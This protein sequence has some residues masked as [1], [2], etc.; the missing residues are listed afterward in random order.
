[1][2]LSGLKLPVIRKKYLFAAAGAVLLAAVLLHFW[3]AG[4]VSVER[5]R[6]TREDVKDTCTEDGRITFGDSL[7]VTALVSGSVKEVRAAENAAVKAGDILFLIDSSDYENALELGRADLA[8]SEAE[9]SRSS[10][11]QMMTSSPAEYLESAKAAET[12]AKARYDAAKKVYEGDKVLA[13]E[14]LVSEL[15]LAT[16]KAEYEAAEAARKEAE[17]RVAEST[18]KLS[19]LNAAGISGESVNE[20]FYESEK[21]ALEAA[22]DAKKT[23]VKQLEEDVSRCTV[24]AGRDGIVTALPVKEKTFIQAGEV[25]AVLGSRGKMRA[26]ADILTSAAPYIKKG[27]PVEAA[28]NLRGEKELYK[29][30]VAEVYDYASEGVSA[31]GLSEYRVHVTADLEENEALAYR[32][33]YGADL[34]FILYDEKDCLTVPAAA[35]FSTDGKDYIFRIEGGKAVQTE[36]QLLYQS[37]LTAVVG[38]GVSEGDEIVARR[39]ASGLHDGVRVR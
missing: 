19:E 4:A 34:T 33:G 15:D 8:I 32:N 38:G 27:S 17:A 30:T 11:G 39:D 2:K 24:R 6:V 23:K 35:V 1:M 14:G 9:L 10:I 29:G 21:K 3:N 25:G 22:V 16:H 13:A 28:I 18:K 26:E 37:G 36:I 12:A 31:L 20:Q 5:A 7:Q